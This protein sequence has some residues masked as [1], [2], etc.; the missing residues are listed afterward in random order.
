MIERLKNIEVLSSEDREKI[1]NYID[2]I[3]RDAKARKSY[4]G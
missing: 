2:L 4:G 3:I 1:F